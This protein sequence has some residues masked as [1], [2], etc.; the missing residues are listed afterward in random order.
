MAAARSHVGFTADDGFD[1]ELDRGLIKFDGAEQV[2]MIGHAERRHFIFR[3]FLDQ[4]FDTAGAVEETVL[5]MDVK[6]DKI[7]MIR[8]RVTG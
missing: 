8:H 1:A 2:A 7:R 6:V 5:G 3:C 4:L